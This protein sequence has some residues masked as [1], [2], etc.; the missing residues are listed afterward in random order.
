MSE[1][2]PS[3]RGWVAEQVELYEGSRGTEGLTFSNS[4]YEAGNRQFVHFRPK[5]WRDTLKSARF[6]LSC[7]DPLK[8]EVHIEN[9]CYPT[10]ALSFF[11]GII[12]MYK[13][14]HMHIYAM[15]LTV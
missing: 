14:S 1:H 3:P 13:Y 11:Y 9:C 10:L 8:K 12:R 2:I 5:N 4:Q 7:A 6:Q 15:S